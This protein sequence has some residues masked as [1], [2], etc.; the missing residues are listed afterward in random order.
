MSTQRFLA[1]GA[2]PTLA[3][4][5]M[6]CNTSRLLDANYQAVDKLLA[7][8]NQCIPAKT[9]ILVTTAVDVD[10]L[11]MSSTLGRVIAEQC[12]AR[13]VQRGYKVLN[14][15]IR[16]NSVVIN[17]GGEFVLSRDKDNLSPEFVGDAVLVATYARAKG[18]IDPED[19]MRTDD[20]LYVSIKLVKA[21]DNTVIAATDYVIPCDYTVSSME[22]GAQT[23]ASQ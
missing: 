21:L 5:L 8:P 2:A 3:F 7:K 16:K 19:A 4:L 22:R 12:S 18:R 15:N 14:L 9:R 10:E 17:K 6:G 1:L 11:Q 23:L 13:L 20:R